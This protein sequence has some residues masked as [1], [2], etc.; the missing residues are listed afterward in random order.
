M[1]DV[2]SAPFTIELCS[3]L[4][5]AGVKGFLRLGEGTRHHKTHLHQLIATLVALLQSSAPQT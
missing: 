3:E 4:L 5:Q 2:G 1:G